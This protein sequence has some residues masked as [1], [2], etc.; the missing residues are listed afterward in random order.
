MPLCW[1]RYNSCDITYCIAINFAACKSNIFEE[2]MVFETTNHCK[3]PLYYTPIPS[4]L[5]WADP[6]VKAT[7]IKRSIFMAFFI[8]ASQLKITIGVAEIHRVFKNA[9]IFSNEEK[10]NSLN[11]SA[12]RW[13][14]E[15]YLLLVRQIICLIFQKWWWASLE[16]HLIHDNN[17]CLS[18]LVS[19]LLKVAFNFATT[20]KTLL[21]APIM[22]WHPICCT[23]SSYFKTDK[24]ALRV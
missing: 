7:G 16:C 21:K 18:N 8:A 5:F 13:K 2:N 17:W 14:G 9:S 19:I 6:S 15:I 24:D 4:R 20:S 11:F 1:I 3:A 22:P 12:I 10:S 23:L